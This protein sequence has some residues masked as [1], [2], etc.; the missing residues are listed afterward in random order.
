MALVIFIGF[1]RGLSILRVM[2]YVLVAAT[3]GILANGLR[4]GLIGI[5]TKYYGM[6]SFHGPFDIF[7]STFVFLAGFIVLGTLMRMVGKGRERKTL[8][9]QNLSVKGGEAA[10]ALKNKVNKAAFGVGVA[11]L[12]ATWAFPSFVHPVN[13][14]VERDLNKFPLGVGSWQGRDVETLGEPYEKSVRFDSVL[15]RVYQDP[16]GNRV[17]LF[18]G[19]INSQGK[20]REIDDQP[21]GILVDSVSKFDVKS[22]SADDLI[23]EAVEYIIG[24][25]RHKAIYCY[26]VNGR[27]LNHRYKAK[28]ATILS[29][30]FQR[31]TNAAIIL[32]SFSNGNGSPAWS[33]ETAARNFIGELVPVVQTYM[34][35]TAVIEGLP[36][37]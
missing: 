1:L 6:E 11:L 19:Y 17:S 18:I 24:H 20:D 32:V 22:E 16:K 13:I 8:A 29:G 36:V 21:E 26:Y 35:E 28:I 10:F 23:L 31:K 25:E 7:Y 5:W 37:S 3:V 30:L 9:V 14:A 12:L 2:L 4:V 15:K 34:G 27:I 33:D